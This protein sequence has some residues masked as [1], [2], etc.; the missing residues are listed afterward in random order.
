MGKPHI[1]FWLLFFSGILLLSCEETQ[2]MNEMPIYEGPSVVWTNVTTLYSDSA[3]VRLKLVASKELIFE[4]QDQ[5]FPEG[6]YLELY[7][8]NG[9]MTTTI[10][11]NYCYY[12]NK[13]DKYRAL[14]DVVVKNITNME[15]IHTEE[16]FWDRQEETV[17]TNKFVLIQTQDEI[18]FG[19]GMEASQDMSWWRILK[20][21]GTIT[22]DEKSQ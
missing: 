16:L 20:V 11:A 22:L 6:I 1:Y 2:K 17:Y 10:T 15:E 3:V 9:Q 8:V 7:D 14:R 12:Y 5:E 4:N 18:L 19:E 21:R 13:E